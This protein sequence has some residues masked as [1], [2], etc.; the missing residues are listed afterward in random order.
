MLTARGKDKDGKWVYGNYCYQEHILRTQPGITHEIIGIE[1]GQYGETR[2]SVQPD[3]VSY[4]T[5][6]FDKH[7]DE[8]FGGM[9]LDAGKWGTYTVFWNKQRLCWGTD[10]ERGVADLSEWLGTNGKI[11]EEII[12]E[13]K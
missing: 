1:H 6:L 7:G 4:S 5:G 10:S 12:E 8:I 9:S 3:S 13:A 11:D 2:I